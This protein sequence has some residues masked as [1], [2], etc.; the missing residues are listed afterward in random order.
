MATTDLL[1]TRVGAMS[2]GQ[3]KRVSLLRTLLHD[4]P[5]L[6]LD[7]P[8]SGLDQEGLEALLRV[9]SA[10]DRTVVMSTHNFENGLTMARRIIILDKGRAIMDF[11][12]DGLDRS[13]LEQRYGE[14]V[15]M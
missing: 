15:K 14:L 10:D 5:L 2:H 4:P 6:L 13:E 7:E 12:K 9:V 8:D 3:R 11:Q 1:G